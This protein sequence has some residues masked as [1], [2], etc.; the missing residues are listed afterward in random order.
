MRATLSVCCLANSPGPF[1]R[2]ALGSLR[3]LADEIV[4]VAG[5]PVAEE[6]LDCYAEIAD[7]LFSIEFDCVER[8]LGWMHAQCKC[9]WILRLDGDEIP[10]PE[11]LAEVRAA[12]EDRHL[13]SLLFAR[14]NLFPDIGSFLTQEPWYPDLQVRMGRNDGALRFSG[15]LHSAAERVLPARATEAAIYH[16]PFILGGLEER[17]AR[18]E[19][20]EA[21]R[22]GLTAPTGLPANDALLP[23]NLPHLKTAPVP[24]EHRQLI[25]AVLSSSAPAR[26][27]AQPIAVPLAEMD[28][29]WA[30]RSLAESAYRASIAVV[31]DTVPFAPAER[32]PTYFQVVNRGDERWGW[33]PSIGPYLHV[34]HRLLAEDHT[35]VEDWRPSFF[36]EWVGPGATTVVP[37]TVDAPAD[38]GRYR[39]EVKIRHSPLERLFGDAQPQDVVVQ[40]G[41]A[42]NMR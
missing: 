13:N 33:D 14:R 37:A 22:P 34:V 24:V 4:I 5:G 20:Y 40:H 36:T 17:K 7:R 1:L 31:G 21:R 32:R 10:T 26:R 8:H 39:L 25:E 23:E 30:G 38:P 15:L 19:R 35:P 2:A 41:G 3:E 42:W 9:D 28:P 18:A 12:T 29:Y 11:M 16:L 6:D 27:S